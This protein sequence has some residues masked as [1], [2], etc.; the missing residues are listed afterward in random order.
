MPLID[1][2]TNLKDL[3]YGH[4]QRDGV[5]SNQ[6]FVPTLIP[7]NE[8]PLAN[9]YLP[10]GIFPSF[11]ASGFINL[12]K[13]DLANT[14]ITVGA[15]AIG[16]ALIGGLVGSPAIGALVGASAAG[17]VGIGSTFSNQD[18]EAGL[19]VTNSGFQPVPAS[20]G[21]GGPDFLV[22]GGLLLPTIVSKDAVR[23]SRFLS[24]QNGLF[25][26]LKQQLLSRV[27]T[28]SEYAGQGIG[29][30]LNDS[31]YNPLSTVLGAVGAPFGL[32]T[33]K[34]GLN[35]L[36][37][38]FKEYTPD[39]YYSYIAN[40]NTE[41]KNKP[42]ETLRNRL[43]SLYSL[44]ILTSPFA[45]P[46]KFTRR[47][48]VSG[49]P[50]FIISYQ[51]GP[52]SVL[53]I[54]KTRIKYATNQYDSTLS[55][56][57][58]VNPYGTTLFFNDLYIA[59]GNTYTQ[60]TSTSGT[61]I[62]DFRKLL[63]KNPQ[64]PDVPPY[65][66]NRVENRVNL[67]DPGNPNGKKISSYYSGFSDDIDISYGAAS[68]NSYDK[69]TALPIYR[70][71]DTST[72]YNNYPDLVDFRIGVIDNSSGDIDNVHFRAFLN[73]I[74]DNYDANW[75]TIKYIGRGE[76]FYTYSGFDRKISLSWT[77]AAQSKIELIPMYKK[78]N[79]LASLTAPDYGKYGYM[80]ANIIQLTIG[81]YLFNQPGFINRIGYEI[82]E[83]TTWEIGID[84]DFSD[85][86]LEA[87]TDGYVRQLPHM[88]K[89]NFEFTP[90]HNFVPRKQQNSYGD[91][92]TNNLG[93]VTTYGNEQFIAL[94]D[95]DGDL[96]NDP[97][98]STEVDKKLYSFN[99]LPLNISTYDSDATATANAVVLGQQANAAALSKA[100]PI[101]T[102][103]QDDYL[104]A[105]PLLGISPIDTT[106][107]PPIPVKMSE[108]P[109]NPIAQ[110][111]PK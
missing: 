64:I 93:Q 37:G 21:T 28:R 94:A 68:P 53:G 102:F 67:G 5:S 13:D 72:E 2:K 40:D 75:N 9:N 100:D 62:I 57:Q 104:S 29:G 23:M 30:L 83:D 50:N 106:P 49:D 61:T 6:P 27:S 80:R 10:K 79:Y 89:V 3:K 36:A 60:N 16:G 46:N 108:L 107:V 17:A 48:D 19:K 82:S 70:T 51:G 90:I 76:N 8:D 88:I 63:R 45:S 54:G 59:A 98:V 66:Q 86:T 81:G 77:V 31:V 18:I 25:F 12:K 47:N 39:R 4:D 7:A 99:G 22:R 38:I 103:Y 101:I 52:G 87:F 111:F 91:S 34:Q 84:N 71:T 14:A 41:I 56:K 55:V 44:K 35:P 109:I 69:I 105:D 15:G 92:S 20:S 26:V 33:N 74:N 42:S 95:S 110:M 78:L 73:S 11:E 24:S 43:Y 1:L 65:E 32:H 58:A 85:S 97:N 96:Y